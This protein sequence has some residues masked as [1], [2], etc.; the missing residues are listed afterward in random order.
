MISAISFNALVRAYKRGGRVFHALRDG[1][2][3]VLGLAQRCK[4][5]QFIT[6]LSHFVFIFSKSWSACS[7]FDINASCHNQ[8][9]LYI[10]NPRWL[11]HFY[12]YL[13]LHLLFSIVIYIF[14]IYTK[15]EIR[16]GSATFIFICICIYFFLSSFTFSCAFFGLIFIFICILIFHSVFISIFIRVCIFV[17]P[18][19][20]FQSA[21]HVYQHLQL[22]FRFC[23]LCILLDARPKIKT[24]TVSNH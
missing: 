22:R 18:A 10:R 7:L 6:R 21:F 4:Q 2:L 20:A 5:F 16:G 3:E 13:H 12:F 17:L 14:L 23:L 1:H 11:S 19:F 24:K 8:C 15:S 9:V